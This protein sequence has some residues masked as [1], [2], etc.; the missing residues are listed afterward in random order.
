MEQTAKTHENYEKD[1][2]YGKNGVWY[3]GYFFPVDEI[4]P[5]KTIVSTLYSSESYISRCP[6]YCNLKKL[7]LTEGQ[8]KRHE[9]RKK[10][11]R[12]FVKAPYNDSYWKALADKKA[13]KKL[14]KQ[15]ELYLRRN[16]NKNL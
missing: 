15:T 12:H 7:Y 1:T 16:P 5:E 3:D 6:G 8:M 13:S 11:C 4:E 9:C 10:S 14:K 2:T